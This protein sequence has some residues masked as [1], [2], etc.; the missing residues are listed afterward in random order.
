MRKITILILS[1]LISCVFISC[2]KNTMFLSNQLAPYALSKNEETIAKLISGQ[3]QY[4]IFNFNI[5]KKI[6]TLSIWIEGYNNGEKLNLNNYSC[7]SL[8]NPTG[9]ISIN[10]NTSDNYQW[11]FSFADDE[12]IANYSFKTNNQFETDSKYSKGYT[13]LLDPVEISID[14]EIIL[15]AYLF[16]DNG[17]MSIY[18]TNEYLD[19][20]K[21]LK[22]FD[23][24]YLVKCKFSDKDSTLE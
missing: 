9:K 6:K 14:K 10:T 17:S 21:I 24:V 12:N 13:K 19:N 22:E 18:S 15:Q 23:Y 16:K 4:A 20:P 7:F 2:N 11:N 1:L 5:D 8:K 3:S